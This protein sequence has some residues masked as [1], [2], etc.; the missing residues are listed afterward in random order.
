MSTPNPVP[1]IPNFEQSGAMLL[2]VA[3]I[4]GAGST[5]QQKL[6]AAMAAQSVASIFEDAASGN[7]AAIN[8]EIASLVGSIKDPGLALVAKQLAT[9]GQPY[10]QVLLNTNAA[11]PLIGATEQAILSSVAAGMNQAAQA[12]ITAYGSKPAA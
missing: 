10:L 12:Y 9:A 3:A 5:P 7:A 4:N 8:A 6:A 11:L 2:T 1:A